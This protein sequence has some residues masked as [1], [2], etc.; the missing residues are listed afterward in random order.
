MMS[1]HTGAAWLPLALLFTLCVASCSGEVI[2]DAQ[3]P[4]TADAGVGPDAIDERIGRIFGN[5]DELGGID[6]DV[7]RR[8][9]EVTARDD[10][11]FFMVNFIKH[12]ERAEYADGRETELTGAEADGIYGQMFLPILTDIGARPVFVAEVE[13]TLMG[14]DDVQ[15]DQVGVV[16]Y[17]SRGEFFEMLERADFEEAAA[18]KAA[19]V[20]TTLVMFALP[21]V[22]DELEDLPAVDLETVPY[23]PTDADSPL[24]IIHLYAYRELAQYADGRETELTGQ[25]AVNTYTQGRQDQ[26]VTELGVR[27]G[28]WLDI[29]GPLIADERSFDEFRINLFPSHATFMDVAASAGEAGIEHRTAGLEHHYTLM[30]LPLINEYGYE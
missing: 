27:P 28:L 6:R 19:G 17:P 4:A 10:A 7:V 25:E 13:A 9:L 15:W 5:D 1:L 21:I 16:H 2:K 29:D 20:E 18:H 30:T 23:P 22:N 3:D 26:G 8:M 14:D 24:A 11:P 12:R